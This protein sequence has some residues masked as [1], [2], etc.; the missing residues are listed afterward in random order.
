MELLF[1]TFEEMS[2]SHDELARANRELEEARAE[3]DRAN[4]AKSQF[5]SRMS[6]ELRTP[7][8]AILGFAQ[9]L[10]LDELR[11]DQREGVEHILSGARHLLGLI[12]EVLDI[13]AIEAG[14]LP[15]SLEPV[16]VAEV[17]AEAVSLIRP[18]ADQHK[19]VLVD[20]APPCQQHVLADRQRLKQV[21]LNLLSNAV[22]Y[23]RA[24]GSVQLAC[25]RVAGDRL[26]V[27]VTDTGLG[28]TPEAQ[29]RLFVPFERLSVEQTAVEGSGLGLPSPSGWPKRW[30]G[31][32]G[33]SAPWVRAAASG[34]SY[35]S[36]TRRTRA[37]SASSSQL[38]RSPAS[39]RP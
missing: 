10:Q 38:G 28:I 32:W 4:R 21:L 36:P 2:R 27:R 11:D 31:P 19:V 3:A 1:S 39:H 23:N 35:P 13:A 16:A 24:G 26:Q 14:R 37:P 9:L 34:S 30:A 5:L 33:W 25:Q 12:N 22:K 6:H 20:P 15:L 8:N 18:L 17:V 29:Q 7:L